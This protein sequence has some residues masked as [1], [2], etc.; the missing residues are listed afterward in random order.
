MRSI[1]PNLITSLILLVV[2]PI[3]SSA[4]ENNALH[5]D[6]IDDHVQMSSHVV[7]TSGDFTVEFWINSASITGYKEFMSQGS[8]G[9]AFYF[10]T[11][12]GSGIIHCGDKWANTGVVLPLNQW[13]HLALRK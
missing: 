3:Q 1:R 10:G 4:Q 5:F 2:C 6:G 11:I 12:D 7:P 9:D 8:S 13:V